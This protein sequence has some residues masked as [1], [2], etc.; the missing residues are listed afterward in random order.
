MHLRGHCDGYDGPGG[1]GLGGNGYL[2]RT[3][4]PNTLMARLAALELI[5][6][7]EGDCHRAGAR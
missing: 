1:V 3:L 4:L 7:N 6:L 2:A 5:E